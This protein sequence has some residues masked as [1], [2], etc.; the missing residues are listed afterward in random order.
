M[1]RSLY[2]ASMYKYAYTGTLVSRYP[3]CHSIFPVDPA[4]APAFLM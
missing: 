3:Y 1:L 4:S 2:E